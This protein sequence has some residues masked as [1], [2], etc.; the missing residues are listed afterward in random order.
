MNA[1]RIIP[2]TYEMCLFGV[3]LHVRIIIRY[4][5]FREINFA[6]IEKFREFSYARRQ[7]QITRII[8]KSIYLFIAKKKIRSEISIHVGE[9]NTPTQI[10]IAE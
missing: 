9:K 7:W 6:C 3:M 2:G 10:H 5:F 1:S 8:K 4:V